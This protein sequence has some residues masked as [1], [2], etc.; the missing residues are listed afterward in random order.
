MRMRG[1]G[2]S[3]LHWEATR[4]LPSRRLRAPEPGHGIADDWPLSYADLEPFYVRAER[5][6]RCR[7]DDGDAE[8]AA[9]R[10]FRSR[11]SAELR[12]RRL[13]RACAS[14]RRHDAVSRRRGTPRR[15]TAAQVPRMRH[16]LR[17]PIGARASVDL[18]HVPRRGGDGTRA[19]RRRRA[20]APPRVRSRRTLASAV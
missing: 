1:V 12:R 11:L 19:R 18:T 15:T 20:R 5:V 13:A 4:A 3:T 10:R 14:S 6:A 17:C 8:F 9:A 16:L 7:R 2:G